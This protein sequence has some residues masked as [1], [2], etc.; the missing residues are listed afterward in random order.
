MRPRTPTPRRGRGYA[1]RALCSAAAALALVALATGPVIP[2]SAAAEIPNAITSIQVVPSTPSPGDEIRLDLTWAVPD[3]AREGDTF[4]LTLPGL[5]TQITS[6]FDLRDDD[7]NLV[8][9]ATVTQGTVTFTLTDF[10]NTQH[11]VHGSAYFWA[12]ISWEA[13]PG[14]TITLEYGVGS[15]VITVGEATGGDPGPVEPTLTKGGWWWG[16]KPNGEEEWGVEGDY[17]GYAITTPPGPFEKIEIVDNLGDG[18]EYVCDAQL[19]PEVLLWDVDENGGLTNGREKAATIACSADALTVMFTDVPEGTLAVLNYKVRVTDKSLKKYTNGATVTID[20]REEETSAEV[21]RKG[22]G[23]SGTGETPDT[24]T[25]TVVKS[26][27]PA[28]G[29]TVTK[30]QVVTY[31]LAFDHTGTGP[32]DVDFTDDLTDVLDDATFVRIEN[33][34]GLTVSGPTDGRLSITGSLAADTTVVYSV[35]VKPDGRGDNV[36]RNAVFKG[37]TP[38]GPGTEHPVRYLYVQ[39][40]DGTNPL[41][42]GVQFALRAELDGEPGPIVALDAVDET[43][44]FVT[45]AIEPGTYLLEEQRAPDG[46]QL[47]ATPVRFHVAADGAITLDDAEADGGRVTV[48]THG[49]GMNVLSVADVKAPALPLTGGSGPLAYWL[50]GSALVAAATSLAVRRRT[51]PAAPSISAEARR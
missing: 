37:D 35:Q 25:V 1:R 10:V 50:C 49:D 33:A 5:L 15:T 9:Y 34:G 41:G 36:L 44:L 19:A 51:H 38:E 23:G 12:G 4:S 16:L 11:N 18:Q 43:G 8:A 17:I 47:L 27:S 2:A 28:S 24:P 48:S 26:A 22:A 3:T 32:A 42:G 14:Q 7:N 45:G 20:S 46:Y 30:G 40:T 6:E 29:T 39:K 31:S 21:V 13:T